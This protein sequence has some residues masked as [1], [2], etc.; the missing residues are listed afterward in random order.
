MQAA[1]KKFLFD[2]LDTPSP[3]GWEAPGQRKWA[4][5]A[6]KFSDRLENDAYGNAWATIEGSAAARSRP[7]VM[8]E[9]HADE[10]GFIVKH[11]SKE[12]F[13]S[14]DRVGGVD[15]AVARGKRVQ[16]L[17]E[18]GT[19]FGVIGNTA[20]HIRDRNE[21]PPQVH[22]LFV[23]VGAS[24]QEEVA[25]LGIRV[26]IP[27][28]YAESAQKFGADKI[29]GRALDNRIGG[30]IIAEVLRKLR[31]AR[32]KPKANVVAANCVHEEI[33][34]MGS[35]MVAHRL[36][37]DVCIVLDVTHATDT[38]TIS[39]EQH[40]EVALGG[41]PT[42]THGAAN[43]V[44]VVEQLMSVAKNAK[45]SLQHEAASRFTGTDADHIYP[46][47]E[48]IPTALVSLPLRYMHSV[49]E[50]A[51]ERD[52]EQTVQLLSEFAKSVIGRNK[53]DIEL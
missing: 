50:V 49:V 32:S 25:K 31:S 45:I 2:L 17:G 46:T 20:I 42:V 18:K 47:R 12:G 53:F 19:V 1:A 52:I 48:G 40:G 13:L 33:G 21:K 8:L 6:K 26:G 3:T 24:S 16:I 9:A 41:G 29:V 37:P 23:D 38:P 44:N 35:M 51:Q 27:M 28:V 36:N 14:V 43:H 22:E 11:I 39:F 7:T 5:Y 15:H 34:G 4:S 30:F 10:I